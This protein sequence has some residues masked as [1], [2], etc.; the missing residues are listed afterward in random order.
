M[1]QF[2][3]DGSPLAFKGP[4]PESFV[5]RGAMEAS[6]LRELLGDVA[7]GAL[8]VLLLDL[9]PGIQRYFELCDL[10]G[11]P[12][13]VLTVTIPTPESRDAVRRAMRAAVERGSELL[14]IVENMVGGELKGSAGEE[15]AREFGVSVARMPWHPST[16]AW[17]ELGT[18]ISDARR[19]TNDA[20]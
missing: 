2:L 7:W 14:G 13:P 15:L 3:D 12:P 16:E 4:A 1:G 19:T 5:W 18:R 9:P 20:R 17:D 11:N 10:L 6:A 8:D